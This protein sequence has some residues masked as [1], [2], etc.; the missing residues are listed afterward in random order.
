MTIFI[1]AKPKKSDDQTN[2]EKYRVVANIAEYYIIGHTDVLVLIIELFR[3]LQG[4]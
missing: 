2:I 1:K 3:F 4:T